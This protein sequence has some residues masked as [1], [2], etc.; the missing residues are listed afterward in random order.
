MD[1]PA[2]YIIGIILLSLLVSGSVALRLSKQTFKQIDTIT[3]TLHKI[4]GGNFDVRI[5]G[6]VYKEY[7]P[8]VENINAMAKELQ[9]IETLRSDF[10]NN[11]SHEL[12]TPIVSIRGF[13]KLLKNPNLSE[14]DK[15]EYVDIIFTESARLADL[16]NNTLLL[17]KLESQNIISE[18]KEYSL[19]E[20]L[21][22]CVLIL[23]NQW[24]SKNIEM[25]INIP[26]INVNENSELLQ[27]LWLNLL[28]NAVKF[29]YKNGIIDITALETEKNVAVTIKD[30]GV[31]MNEETKKHL[32]EKYYQGDRSHSTIGNGLGLS[33]V[34]RIIDMTGGEIT[35]KSEPDKGSAFTVKLIKQI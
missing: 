8:I 2:V 28:S 20:Q 22:R 21:R 15:K 9:S 18:K 19:S 35:V 3:D 14:E 26:E 31:G 24:E 6:S 25:N 13:A 16:T 5:T 27:Q 32:F 10:I 17:S 23:E 34:K 30:Y 4:G 11:F 7:K 1:A 33:I 29:S 12:K